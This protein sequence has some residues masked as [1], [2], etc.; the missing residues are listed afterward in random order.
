MVKLLAHY[1]TLYKNLPS[2]EKS[3]ISEASEVEMDYNEE[4]SS[5]NTNKN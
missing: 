5:L 3:L 1:E 2:H 4:V